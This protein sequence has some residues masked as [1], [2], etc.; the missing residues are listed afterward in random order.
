MQLGTFLEPGVFFSTALCW[1]HCVTPSFCRWCWL[2]FFSQE[3]GPFHYDSLFLHSSS[4]LVYG[5]H[6]P[7]LTTSE[8]FPGRTAFHMLSASNSMQKAVSHMHKSEEEEPA[9]FF[10]CE[11]LCAAQLIRKKSTR[12]WELEFSLGVNP[13]IKRNLLWTSE[14]AL[15]PAKVKESLAHAYV[16]RFRDVRRVN[17]RDGPLQKRVCLAK[18]DSRQSLSSSLLSG[19]FFIFIF[20][21]V[22]HPAV[23]MLVL[24]AFVSKAFL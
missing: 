14:C 12:F 7:S 10:H 22:F 11:E 19:T 24:S 18:R 17:M 1:R 6:I 15:I 8:A 16:W 21:L 9:A 4:W 5:L 23:Y 13:N 20:Y 2:T 3:N